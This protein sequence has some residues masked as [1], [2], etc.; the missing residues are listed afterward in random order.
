MRAYAYI[1]G[2]VRRHPLS[3]L[4]VTL[5]LTIAFIPGLFLIKGEVSQQDMIPPKFPSKKAISDLNRI[6]GGTSFESILIYAPRVTNNTITQFLI[7]LEDYINQDPELKDA[8]AKLPL[9]MPSGAAW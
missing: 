7:G 5:V 8:I 9:T 3:I 4:T 2:L 1:A 6:F